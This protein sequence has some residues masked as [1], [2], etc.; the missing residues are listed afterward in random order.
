MPIAVVNPFLSVL[1]QGCG[2]L[3]ASF[4]H[5]RTRIL[6]WSFFEGAWAFPDAT[7]HND[8]KY[9]QQ[10]EYNHPR[11]VL[12]DVKMVWDLPGR[13][14]LGGLEDRVLESIPSVS[15]H[16]WWLGPFCHLW[17]LP[18]R[19][20]MVSCFWVY[21]RVQVSSFILFSFVV[22]ICRLWN[23]SRDDGL[24]RSKGKTWEH[25][26]KKKKKL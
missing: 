8:H 26:K 24:V 21:R 3:E 1:G 9:K 16:S 6:L 13:P 17:R 19:S 15:H 20:L 10:K 14:P 4:L 11:Q 25:K 2:L 12:I 18:M 5:N 23:T 7:N 22:N